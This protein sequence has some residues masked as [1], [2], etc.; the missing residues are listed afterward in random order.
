[1]YSKL[2]GE[3]KKNAIDYLR[4][5]L[6]TNHGTRHEDTTADNYDDFEVDEKYYTYPVCSLE[7]T[8]YEIVGRIDRIH[9]D[10]EGV[11]TIV[12]IKNRARGLFKTVRDYE[13]V[14]CQTYMEMLDIDN[15]QL[16]EQYN[17]SRLG[18]K[19]NRDRQKWLSEINPRL[20]NFCRHF[21]SLLSK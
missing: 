2:R 1:M 3:D 7:G 13:E 17:E 16:I 19:I 15:C 9:T 5:K 4:K 8:D 12:E 11:K 6:Y 21:H 10:S 14:Q 18:Y 20:V